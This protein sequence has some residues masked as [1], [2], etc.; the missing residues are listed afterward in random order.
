MRHPLA[1]VH[2]HGAPSPKRPPRP[3]APRATPASAGGDPVGP[4]DPFVSWLFERYGLDA[5]AYNPGSLERRLRAC[6]RALRVTSS[7]EARALL[8]ARP[9]RGDVAL[10]AMLV[11]V[12]GFFRDPRV[13]DGLATRV[14]P[15]LAA[16]TGPIR[17]LGVGVSD[18]QELWTMAM[19][20]EEAGTLDRAELVG[21]DCRPDAIARARAA[22]YTEVEVAGLSE[23]RRARHLA[24]AGDRWVVHPRLRERVAF[25]VGSAL[26]PLTAAEADVALFRNVAIYLRPEDATRAWG[27]VVAALAPGGVVVTGTAERPPERLRL[28]PVSPCA[29][30][31]AAA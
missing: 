5:R 24:R 23:E 19:L 16:R 22:E 17:V 29:F 25:R 4:A 11:G 21:L 13:F 2:F 28:R 7:E 18:G 10:D 1:H 26:D 14:L 30:R 20:L 31:R 12:S 6:L 3:P 9:E 15:D 27:S 8:E